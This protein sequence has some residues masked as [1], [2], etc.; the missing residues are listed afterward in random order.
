MVVAIP[1]FESLSRYTYSRS[2]GLAA[3]IRIVF[4]LDPLLT[5]A[6]AATLSLR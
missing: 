5:E 6:R 3:S 2:S 1:S 4:R